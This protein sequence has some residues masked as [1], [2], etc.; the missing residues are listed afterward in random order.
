MLFTQ[1]HTVFP[2]PPEARSP[3]AVND[4]WA[5]FAIERETPLQ[6]ARLA[7]Q[8]PDLLRAPRGSGEPVLLI[9][10]FRAH[11]SSMY[12]L[13]GYLR[14][15]G[16]DAKTWG[17]GFNT[18]RVR[19]DVQALAPRVQTWHQTTGQQV[20]LVG[21]SLG[22]VISREVARRRPEDVA[23]VFTYGSP[24]IGGPRYTLAGRHWTREKTDELEQQQAALDRARPIR[25]PVTA[26]FSRKDRIV[27]WPACIDRRT[28]HI[29]HIEVRSTHIGMGVDPD[30]WRQIA[31]GLKS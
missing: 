2:E 30:V 8:T 16:Y 6:W 3:R 21:W 19:R 7:A 23:H 18:G 24:V 22:G 29:R 5:A 20:R 28:P 10:G 26:F 15:L 9:P 4:R 31:W 14:W 27:D 13:M 17:R 1:H 25:V 12:L 11:E